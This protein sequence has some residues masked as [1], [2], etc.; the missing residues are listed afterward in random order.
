MARPHSHSH[1]TATPTPTH[2]THPFAPPPALR[3]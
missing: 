3:R 1:P 2:F